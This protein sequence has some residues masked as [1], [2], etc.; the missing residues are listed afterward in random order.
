MAIPCLFED[1]FVVRSVDNSKFERV[2]RIRAKSSG[3]DADLTLDVHNQLLPVKEKHVG[4]KKTFLT[5][6]RPNLFKPYWTMR[7]H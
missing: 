5:N 6:V 2:S 7:F 3:L 1:R 4:S